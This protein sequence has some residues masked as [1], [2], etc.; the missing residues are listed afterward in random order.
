MEYY[1]HIQVKNN[2]IITQTAACSRF[3]PFKKKLYGSQLV[4]TQ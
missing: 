2:Y 3:K 1:I 4:M